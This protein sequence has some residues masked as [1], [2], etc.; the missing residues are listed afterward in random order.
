MTK[1]KVRWWDGY[2]EEFEAKEV[3]V[4]AYMLWMRLKSEEERWI[5]LNKVRWLEGL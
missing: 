5:P 1:V 3:R 4:G 2:L